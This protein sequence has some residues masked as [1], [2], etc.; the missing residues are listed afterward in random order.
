V[1]FFGT[2]PDQPVPVERLL[3]HFERFAP[4][5]ALAVHYVW[6]DLFWRLRSGEAEWLPPLIRL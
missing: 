4:F 3:H 5:R 2:E 6:E 1:L